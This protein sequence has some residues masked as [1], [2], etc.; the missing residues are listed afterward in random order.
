M[1]NKFE[2]L[3]SILISCECFINVKFLSESTIR[4][5]R[6]FAV[7]FVN[8]SRHSTKERRGLVGARLQHTC[9]VTN[10]EVRLLV[11]DVY[12]SNNVVVII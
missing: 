4:K 11:L 7:V 12:N 2:L 6:T 5:R 1:T 9:R 10:A 3:L 8:S